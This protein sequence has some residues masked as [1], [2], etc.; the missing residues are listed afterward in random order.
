M[1]MKHA[2]VLTYLDDAITRWRDLRDKTPNPDD[3]R[4]MPGA[5]L[6]RLKATYYVD[7]FQSV[8]V[9]LFGQLLDNPAELK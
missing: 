7:A 4:A 6:Q 1:K 5:N 9:S 2:E 8:R 3:E